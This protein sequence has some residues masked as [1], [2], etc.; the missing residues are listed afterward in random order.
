MQSV[1]HIHTSLVRGEARL[2]DEIVAEVRNKTGTL[3][4]IF[5]RQEAVRTNYEEL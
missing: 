5:L 3:I 4:K 1:F 2:K